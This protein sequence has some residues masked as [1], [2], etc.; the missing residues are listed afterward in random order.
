MA[1]YGVLGDI[2]GNCEALAPVL[3]FFDRRG[4]DCLACVGDIVGFNADPDQCADM[5]RRRCALAVAGNH[6]LIAI[7]RLGFARCSNAAMHA[8]RRTRRRIA[9]H[10]ARYLSSLPSV[11]T[12]EHGVL[13][14]HGGIQDVEQYLVTPRQI[15]QNADDLRANFPGV[16]VCLFGHTHAQKVYEIC[17]SAVSDL[18]LAGPVRLRDDCVYFINPGSV[19][20][21]RKR[22]EKLAECALLDGTARS[23][24]F[25][26][27]P[28]DHAAAEA[29]AAAGGYRL[30]PWAERVYWAQRKLL[31]ALRIAN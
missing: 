3:D 2:H 20:A 9:L 17:G 4:V 19:D 16:R 30:G 31:G 26:R 21:A 8:L 13:L 15:R 10:T 12:L 28:Y 6:D 18:P 27:L 24:E 1:L 14:V 5:I 22:G 11:R 7:G 25:H 29:K 23:V